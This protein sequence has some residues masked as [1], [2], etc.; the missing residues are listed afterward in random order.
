MQFRLRPLN[1]PFSLYRLKPVAIHI[2]LYQTHFC[3]CHFALFVVRPLFIQYSSFLIRQ[4]NLLQTNIL[5]TAYTK[6]KK[7]VPYF[8][9]HLIPQAPDR[10]TFLSIEYV[11]V[12]G[13]TSA[14]WDAETGPSPC[15]RT[16]SRRRTCYGTAPPIAVAA[17]SDEKVLVEVAA[18]TRKGCKTSA[19][20]GVPIGCMPMRF[21]RFF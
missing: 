19:I 7:Y 2:G 14:R 8:L 9:D 12:F 4:R 13:I 15:R 1:C 10:E 20:G 17:H 18:A 5:N 6:R 11:V 3:I 21:A 16:C